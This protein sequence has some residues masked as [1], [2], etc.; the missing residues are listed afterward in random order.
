MS[1]TIFCASS[2]EIP[3][4]GVEK[5]FLCIRFLGILSRR[6]TFLLNAFLHGIVA[7]SEWEFDEFTQAGGF[8]DGHE[9]FGGGAACFSGAAV[10]GATFEPGDHF[11]G[12]FD[13]TLVGFF[14][15]FG[16]AGFV[17]EVYALDEGFQAAFGAHH[18][19]AESVF[20][21]AFAHFEHGAGAGFE[22][23]E[24]QAGFF[25]GRGLVEFISFAGSVT[26]NPVRIWI[27][28]EVTHQVH[29][30]G[31][32]VHDAAGEITPDQAWFAN[33]SLRDEVA[34]FVEVGVLPVTMGNDEFGATFS[35]GVAHGICIVQAQT[36]GFFAEYGFGP[37]CGGGNGL[38]GVGFGVGAD[39]DEVDIFFFLE[40][41]FVGG[42][43]TGNVE[44]VADFLQVFRV[45][46]AGG[47]QLYIS[48]FQI[49]FCVA[50]RDAA[51]SDE[52]GAILGRH[53]K[54]LQRI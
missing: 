42:V 9:Q 54:I 20:K 48:L 4:K 39:A 36:H 10:F 29:N 46:V 24:A 51:A 3:S 49:G 14:A 25:G 35:A 16:E 52:G 27:A 12:L 31:S 19:E 32:V 18:A 47:N 30:V 21:Y 5:T 44:L 13:E 40:E 23:D 50:V 7:D 6:S 43:P 17:V 45:D 22:G 41:V 26:H 33:G 28:Q 37:G 15:D 2:V 38:F 8:V 11:T 34:G 1:S 53:L